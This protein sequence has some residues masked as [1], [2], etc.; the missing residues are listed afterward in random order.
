[1]LLLRLAFAWSEVTPCER[2]FKALCS[3][4]RV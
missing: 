3:L 2:L 1:V 4:R